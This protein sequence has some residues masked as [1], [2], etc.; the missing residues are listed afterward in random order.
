MRFKA[1]E[2]TGRDSASLRSIDYALRDCS[3]G[4]TH[5][6]SRSCESRLCSKGQRD[7]SE[8]FVP[9]PWCRTNGT[10]RTAYFSP[11]PSKSLFHEDRRGSDASSPFALPMLKLEHV[12]SSWRSL[13]IVAR[14]ARGFF[15]YTLVRKPCVSQRFQPSIFECWTDDAPHFDAPNLAPPFCSRQGVLSGILSFAPSAFLDFLDTTRGGKPDHKRVV[16]LRASSG[17]QLDRLFV[18]A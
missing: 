7:Q 9:I 5:T 8:F 15:A 4:K 16:S 14:D 13:S 3:L 6:G 17:T 11:R 18:L 12:D 10:G 2:K 1:K